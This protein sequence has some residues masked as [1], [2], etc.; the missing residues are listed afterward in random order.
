MEPDGFAQVAVFVD[1][2]NLVLG[3]V[4]ELPDQ[5]NPAPYEALTRL[6]RGYGNASVRRAYA[7]WANP[8]FGGHQDDLAMNG[9]D[10]IQVA[11]VGIQN[12]NAADIR[13]AVDA[14]ETLIVHPEVSVFILVSGDGDYSPLVQRLREFGKWV[15]G[16][17]TEANASRSWSRCARSTSTGARWWRRSSRPHGQPRP[18]TSPTPSG[19]WCVRS[20]S[21]ASR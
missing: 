19:C 1:F 10:L 18:S 17:G 3:A 15:V 4:K 11:R 20:R 13:M 16:V 14:M 12:K 21:L 2:E 5:A 8:L 9:V 6:C 7:D